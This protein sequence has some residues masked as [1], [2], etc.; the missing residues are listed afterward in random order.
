MFEDVKGW[1]E[2][3][4]GWGMTGNLCGE[5]ERLAVDALGAIEHSCGRSASKTGRY[6]Y[7]GHES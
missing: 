3:G 5:E 7:A 4:W 1:A 2:I 6:A